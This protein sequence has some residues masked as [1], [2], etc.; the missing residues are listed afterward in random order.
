MEIIRYPADILRQ[1]T[2]TVS[3][4]DQGTADLAAAMLTTMVEGHGI[5]LAGPQVGQLLSLFVAQDENGKPYVFINPEITG[6]SLETVGYEEGCL[7]LPGIYEE[8]I[9]PE[10][11]QIQAWNEKGRFFKMECSGLLARVVQHELDHLKG[12]LFI[13]YLTPP[14]RERL[15]KL[16]EKKSRQ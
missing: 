9:R 4:I 13:D 3:Q 12:T 5:G 2:E 15:L 6:T 16:Y 1:K 8:V 7:S 10:A 11:V 14:K